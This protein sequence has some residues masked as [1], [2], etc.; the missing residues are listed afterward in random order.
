MARYMCLEIFFH[1]R[2]T[3]AHSPSPGLNTDDIFDMVRSRFWPNGIRNTAMTDMTRDDIRAAVGAGLISE[4]QATSLVA[5]AQ[6]RNSERG[7]MAGL[8]EPFELF[9]GFNELLIVVGLIA[10]FFGYGGFFISFLDSQP[11]IIFPSTLVGMG[12]SVGFARYFTLHRR[13][14]APSI[15]LTVIFFAYASLIG[16]FI[17]A[18]ADDVLSNTGMT[19]SANMLLAISI[20]VAVTTLMLAVYHFFFRVPFTL[21][22]IALG[23]L[24]TALLVAAGVVASSGDA[25]SESLLDYLLLSGDE[26]YALLVLAFGLVFLA[27]AMYYDLSDPHRVTRRAACAFWLHAVAAPAIM[28]AIGPTLFLQEANS[29]KLFLFL[30]LV[31][32]ALFALVID[33]RNFIISGMGYFIA[34]F[35]ALLIKHFADMP[36]ILLLGLGL[37][38][39]GAKWE[40]LRSRLMCVL[41]DFPGK[42]GLPPWELANRE[43]GFASSGAR[44]SKIV[45]GASDL[46]EAIDAGIISDTQA[47]S[48]TELTHSRGTDR[49]L[50]SG[51]EEPFELF[52]GFHEIFIVAGLTIFAIGWFSLS[53]AAIAYSNHLSAGVWALIGMWGTIALTKYFTVRRR[54][55]APSIALTVI[56]SIAAIQMGYS[57]GNLA[58]L[59]SW[60]NGESSFATVL[61]AVS[62]ILLAG[63]YFLFRIPFALALIALGIFANAFAILVLG[64]AT[65]ESPQEFLLLSG[66]GPFAILT[67]VLGLVFLVIALTFDM[68]DPHRVTRRTEAG[69]WMHAVA[70]LMIAHAVAAMLNVRESASAQLLLVLFVTLLALL[71]VVIDRRSF[72]IVGTGYI[73]ALLFSSPEDPF[74][75]DTFSSVAGLGLGLVVLG[76]KWQSARCWILRVLPGFPGKGRLPPWGS[77]AAAD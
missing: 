67:F 69:F 33:R 58:G 31:V 23:A 42:S 56:F 65:P 61:T 12:M 35:F 19:D 47:D 27:F 1:T 2:D 28:H 20:G 36:L 48:V 76:A 3:I 34:L 11:W 30:F 52:R 29:G 22:L 71:A 5:K 74:S 6:A 46:R 9:R 49:E 77:T 53:W 66:K 37:I 57:V 68:S 38:Y 75:A 16:F 21:A 7:R 26:P 41:P 72:L 50:V 24:A 18:I 8:D 10:L 32:M 63:Y 64:G 44:P 39:L 17:S 55:I 45:I 40:V 51:L 62:T 54:M 14:I 25:T 15:V 13:M 70:A 73:F 4:A 59:D 60:S 43:D